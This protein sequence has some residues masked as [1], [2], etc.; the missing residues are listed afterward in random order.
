MASEAIYTKEY[1]DQLLALSLDEKVE[2]TKKR[3]RDWYDYWDGNVCVSFSGGKDSTVLLHIARQLYP[4]LKAVYSDTGLEYPEVRQFVRKFDN[5]DIIRPTMMFPQVITKFGY[6][7]ISKEVSEAIE[8]ARRIIPKDAPAPLRRKQIMGVAPASL[9]LSLSLSPRRNKDS[10]TAARRNAR[11]ANL[12]NRGKRDIGRI[13]RARRE[14][15]GKV[16][17]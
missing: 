14:L 11:Q 7:L 6:P 10:G 5:V 4:H 3:I 2:L 9:S 8:Y 13:L 17:I 16:G 15:L 1:L 12:C